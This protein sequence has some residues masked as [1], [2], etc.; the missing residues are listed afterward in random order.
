MKIFI[1]TFDQLSVAELYKALHLR[2]Q[3]FVVEQNC[4]YQDVDNLDQ[5]AWHVLGF[6]GDELV[7]YARLLKPGTQHHEPAIGR[8]VTAQSHRGRNIGKQIFAAS[9]AEINQLF[10]GQPIKIMAQVYL[11]KFYQSFGFVVASQEFLEDGIPHVDMIA[12]PNLP[13]EEEDF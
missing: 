9:L 10:P 2:A 3:V 7:A 4:V 13:K 6:M 12:A 8:V 5:E 11:Q 1:K